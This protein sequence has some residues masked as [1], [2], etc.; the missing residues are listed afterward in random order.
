MASG[1]FQELSQ[2]AAR[3]AR[4]DPADS[5]D[6]TRANE[7]INEAYLSCLAGGE[8]FDFLEMEGTWDCTAGSDTYTY[9]SI[10]TA[11]SVSGGAI[12]E[13]LS[14][15]NDDDGYVLESMDWPDLEKLAYSSQDGDAQGR[16]L[17]WSKWGSK[18]RLYPNPDKAYTL[19]TF[20]RLVPTEMSATTDT[21]LIP[22]Q[23]RHSVLVSHAAANLLRQEG[24]GEAHKEAQMY[25][26]QYDKA[27]ERMRTAHATARKPTFR[28]KSPTWDQDYFSLTRRDPYGWTR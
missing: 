17:Y 15:V 13:I 16:P 6:L 27:W 21:P 22:L 5:T 14:L 12:A 1:D 24:G 25:E 9:A 23:F 28:L 26:R 20:C 10:A 7:A 2:R 3:A 11:I 4:F 8:Q 18:I 19:G